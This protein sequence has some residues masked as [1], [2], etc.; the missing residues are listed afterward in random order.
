MQGTDWLSVKDNTIIKIGE[1]KI[2][3]KK[4]SENEKEAE[5]GYIKL[6]W[7]ADEVK[8]EMATITI[9]NKSKVTGFGGAYWQYFEDLDKIKSNSGTNLSVS[10]ELYLKK[11]TDKGPE[12][13]KITA[14]N[15]L[16]TG[17]L[18]TVRLVISAKEDMEFVH[19]KDMRASCFEPVDVLSGYEYKGGLGFYRSTKDVATHFFFDRINKGTYVLEYDIRVNNLGNF[20]NGIS[21][22]ESMYA[23]EYSSHTKG[24]RVN[25]KE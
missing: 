15:T 24:I 1:E 9:E 16:K 19:L 10:K 7:K 4:L 13:Q 8:K 20:S 23:P 5:T 3:T 17:D 14:K 25:V 12:L 18:V 11:N 22:I 6:S 21:T 2:L